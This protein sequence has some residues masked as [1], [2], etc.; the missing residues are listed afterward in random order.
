MNSQTILRLTALA[1]TAFILYACAPYQQRGSVSG[2]AM[3]GIAGAILDRNNPWRGGVIGAA[4]GAIAGAT[5]ADISTQGGQQAAVASRPVEYRTDD[6][7]AYYYA[8]PIGPDPRTGCTRIREKI[9]VDGELVKK[10][11]KVICRET[12]EPRHE[13]YRHERYDDD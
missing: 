12:Y 7:R 13:R 8:E 10:R 4:L 1:L 3:G 9:Y 5:I 11:V 6:N 2:G